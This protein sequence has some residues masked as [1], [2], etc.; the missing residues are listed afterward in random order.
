M[1]RIFETSK[2]DDGTLYIESKNVSGERIQEGKAWR[3]SQVKTST[4]SLLLLP[5]QDAN[6]VRPLDSTDRKI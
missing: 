2:V 1:S 4:A 6:T 3:G 5:P